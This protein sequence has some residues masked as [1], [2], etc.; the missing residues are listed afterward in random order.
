MWNSAHQKHRRRGPE[1][2]IC[3]LQ[4]YITLFFP[5]GVFSGVPGGGKKGGLSTLGGGGGGLLGGRDQ[6]PL[7]AVGAVQHALP[8]AH[9]LSSGGLSP[10]NRAG[11]RRGR[12][13][14]CY[15]PGGKPFGTNGFFFS[16]RGDRMAENF[17]L[18]RETP[19]GLFPRTTTAYL[20]FVDDFFRNESGSGPSGEIGND[21]SKDF[22][23][24]PFTPQGGLNLWLYLRPNWGGPQGPAYLT[25]NA[26]EGGAGDP[27]QRGDS[28]KTYLKKNVLAKKD[29]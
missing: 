15:N 12:N 19:M 6:G 2:P 7:K 3:G 27:L 26:V 28:K 24:S 25:A 14:T 13:K 11:F 17:G 8:G 21:G 16:G 23:L 1:K 9:S 22:F 29:S 10:F 20:C 4:D 18:D 5:W